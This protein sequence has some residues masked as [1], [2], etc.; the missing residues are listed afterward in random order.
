MEEGGGVGRGDHD[1]LGYVHIFRQTHYHL[2]YAISM[3]FLFE[4]LD[5]IQNLVILVLRTVR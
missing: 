3:Q 5:T 2:Q 1:N 4:S